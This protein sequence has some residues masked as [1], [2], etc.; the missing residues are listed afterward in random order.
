MSWCQ[1]FDPHIPV[2]TCDVWPVKLNLIFI[3]GDGGVV[4]ECRVSFVMHHINFEQMIRNFLPALSSQTK[5][6]MVEELRK[7][8]Q[9]MHQTLNL[10]S[11][12]VKLG[13]KDKLMSGDKK[14]PR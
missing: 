10:I 8:F 7:K 12:L 13:D 2:C 4:I 14:A 6:G 1:Q 5:C 9:E 3:K 11:L